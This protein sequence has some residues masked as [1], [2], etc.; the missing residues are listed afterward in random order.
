MVASG[1]ARLRAPL[2]AVSASSFSHAFASCLNAVRFCVNL[3]RFRLSRLLVTSFISF[4]K[5]ASMFPRFAGGIVI[6]ICALSSP[7]LC[8]LTR[9]R[10]SIGR[11]RLH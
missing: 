10:L 2:A 5:H 8:S 6:V 9:M 4:S 3:S 11:D 7:Y 1:V